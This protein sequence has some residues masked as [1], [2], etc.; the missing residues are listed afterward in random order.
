M[1]MFYASIIGFAVWMAGLGMPD[2]AVEKPQNLRAV[3]RS[4]VGGHPRLSALVYG[5]DR[6]R[7]SAG[8]AIRLD[9]VSV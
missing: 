5:G 3:A 8:Q 9:W 4:S 6:V 1:W 7:R 2:I